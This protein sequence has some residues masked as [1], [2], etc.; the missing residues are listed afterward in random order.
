MTKKELNELLDILIEISEDEDEENNQDK[1]MKRKDI[2]IYEFFHKQIPY[3]LWDNGLYTPLEVG[4]ALRNP[5]YEDYARDNS[6]DSISDWN[7][8]FAE[9][10]G[11]WWVYRNTDTPYVGVCQYRRRLYFPEHYDFESVFADRKVIVPEPLCVDTV[12]AQY[13][14][15]HNEEDLRR[16]GLIIEDKFPE[17]KEDWQKYIV[18]G[19]KLYYGNSV[20]MKR[21][22]FNKFCT[23]LFFILFAFL[24]LTWLASPADVEEYVKDN[25]ER[26]VQC[27]IRGLGYQMQLCGFLTER[28]LTLWIRHNYRQEEIME[29]PYTKMENIGI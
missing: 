26:G 21:E 24:H 28:L 11:I 22:E 14:A 4:A 5:V 16:V 20:I 15:A 18:E 17:Y 3:G 23:W 25:M 6:G 10:T 1:K 2:Q 7:S 13:K 29:I 19:K 27:K 12:Y 8:V 9:T